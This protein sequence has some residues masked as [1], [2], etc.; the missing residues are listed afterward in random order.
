[1]VFNSE[2][3]RK[4]PFEP[5]SR[6][7]RWYACGP[8]VYDEA[9]LGHARSYVASDIVRRILNA[10]CGFEVRL[11]MGV[12]DIDDKIIA[13][14]RERGEDSLQLA[15]R[16]ER[17]FLADMCALNVQPPRL[18]LRVS[19]HVPDIV[20][21]VTRI[22][23]NGLAYRSEGDVLFDVD[24]YGKSGHKYG[25]FREEAATESVAELVGAPK[26]NAA[27]FVLWK[28]SKPGEP[29]WPSPWGPGRP[30]WHIECSAMSQL[31]GAGESDGFA[32]DIHSGGVDLKF[33]H[34][35]NEIA[36]C[37]AHGGYHKPWVRTWLHLGHLHIGGRKM[38]KSL[39][40][41]V[42]VRD[43]LARSTA[44]HFRM[45]CFAHHYRS[46]TEYSEDKMAHAAGTIERFLALFATVRT[47][48]SRLRSLEETRKRWEALEAEFD[49]AIELRRSQIVRALLDDF[50]TPRALSEMLGCVSDT[51]VYLDQCRRADRAPSGELLADCV[52]GLARL[53]AAVGFS[54]FG[55]LA[56]R[57]AIEELWA[58]PETIAGSFA[59]PSPGAK[60][61]GFSAQAEA[62]VRALLKF[63][64]TVREQALTEKNS[65]LLR[66]CD[67]LR[68]V[69]LPPL[70]VL[71]KD[72][73]GGPE[74][75]LLSGAEL[76]AHTRLMETEA[77]HARE[78]RDAAEQARLRAA[79]RLSTPP[80]QLFRTQEPGKYARFDADGVPTHD[81]SDQPLSQTQIR[82]LRK[83][84]ERHK[85][86]W[87][88]RG[89]A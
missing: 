31:Q 76:N 89:A 5:A 14:A 42:S 88:A 24:A 56:H 28:A 20:A 66:V 23:N 33:P 87:D 51:H 64:H 62:A 82:K 32:L 55:S 80:E 6:V 84:W 34:H 39:K 63:R 19:E 26:R 53:F 70:G 65:Q 69:D 10:V 50:D 45:F 58:S 74:L 68:D 81:S 4:E 60:A 29:T 13:R 11:A 30:G 9:H 27:D 22:L 3:G 37:V 35:N 8:T 43:L 41:F 61:G 12:T 78:R 85:R 83:A 71:V 48:L 44:D 38:S 52:D 21:Y 36:Q 46:P 75:A 86:A 17:R 16:Y 40:N 49:A 47:E 57:S 67:A 1:V 7:V 25:V 59:D 15:R 2:S 54:R 18:L 77:A 79:A 72:A 73:S